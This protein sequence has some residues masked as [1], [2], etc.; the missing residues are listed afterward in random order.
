[1]SKYFFLTTLLIAL[2]TSCGN[3]EKK[4]PA[5]YA[6]IDD[7]K[8]HKVG[9]LMGSTHDAY[10]TKKYSDIDVQRIET[11]ADILLSLEG[12]RCD[13]AVLDNIVFN[14]FR[15]KHTN[16]A[17]LNEALFIEPFGIG[18]S[19]KQTALRDQFNVFLAEIKQNGVYQKIYDRWLKH[20]DTAIMPT[21]KIPASGEAIRAGISGTTMPFT[22]IRNGEQVGFDV[23]LLLRFA[24]R[25]QRPIQFQNI[26]FGGLIA[27][28]SAEK[29]DIVS[30][31]MTITEER[32][33]SVAF[34]D[35]YFESKAT[36]T[37][38]QQNLAGASAT[39]AT[40]DNK[41]FIE[42]IKE[43]FVNN[44]L[45]EH[46]YM[47]ILNGLSITL[48][49]SVLAGILGT[50]LGAFVCWLRMN[51]NNFL[52]GTGKLYITLMRGTPVLVLLML[53]YYVIFA[54]WDI[55]GTTVAVITFGLNFAAYASEMFRTGIEGVDR[56]QTE[57]GIALGFTRLKTFI[58][59]VMP[60]AIK[61]VLPVYKGELI[62]LVKTT[63]IVGY[64]AVVD[65]T[66]ASDI[67]RSRTF[68][69]FFPLIM[70]AV[71]YFLLAWLFAT[72][73]DLYN[74]KYFSHS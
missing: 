59:I 13:A 43:N 49:I 60:Q 3:N 35:I 9:V 70:V 38:L 57:A 22:Y 46:R 24:E 17:V 68:D 34:S 19:Y 53:M 45:A 15:K 32:S 21:F 52:C 26:N 55:G 4:T 12:G 64:I 51:N 41:R 40:I 6:S 73:L 39:S 29:V 71:I 56:G 72:V 37:V 58:H 63:S 27:A 10:L 62:S 16:L 20:P 47:L 44:I 30:A 69:A 11:E 18:F 1:M 66:K 31:G 65:L 50:L 14:N 42:R 74:R 5:G 36:L 33:K 48:I 61:S 54:R 2:L 7:L 67:I 28:L 25:L 8:G 23:E